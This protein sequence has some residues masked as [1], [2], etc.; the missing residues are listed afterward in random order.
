MADD[1]KEVEVLTRWQDPTIEEYKKE[2]ERLNDVIKIKDEGI[3]AFAKDL[4]DTT[5]E[6]ERANN[7]NLE[8]VELINKRSS[9]KGK[10]TIKKFLL[11]LFRWQLST[12]TLAIVLYLLHTNTILETIIANLIGGIIFF[13]IDRKIFKER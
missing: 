8:L 13:W 1:G 5:E 9:E 7:K 10:L 2:I 6:L 4:C 12:P 3:K 11:Y